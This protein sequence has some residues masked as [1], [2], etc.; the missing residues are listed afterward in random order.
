MSR[1]MFILWYNQYTTYVYIYTHTS[2][3]VSKNMLS[4][5]LRSKTYF[6]IYKFCEKSYH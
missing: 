3:N 5:I 1:Q 4:Y 6:E 2:R